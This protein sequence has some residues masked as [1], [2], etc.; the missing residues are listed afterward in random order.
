M[1]DRINKIT[2]R[3]PPAATPEDT[4]QPQVQQ[5]Q[6]LPAPPI[7]PQQALGEQAAAGGVQEVGVVAGTGEGAGE[8]GVA[9]A[10]SR[11]RKKDLKPRLGRRCGQCLKYGGEGVDARACK[12]AA[13]SVK[14]PQWDEFG[15]PNGLPQNTAAD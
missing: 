3:A 12:G 11:K 14:C 15:V 6:P 8:Q 1:L 7:R 13:V 10:G 5:Y 9:E 2:Q 4:E